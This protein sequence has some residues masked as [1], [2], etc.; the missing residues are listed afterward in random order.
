MISL[1]VCDCRI[2]LRLLWLLLA[3]GP[4]GACSAMVSFLDFGFLLSEEGEKGEEKRA[5]QLMSTITI[6]RSVAAM[7]E[8]KTLDKYQQGATLAQCP[9]ANKHCKYEHQF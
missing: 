5:V 9:A 4:G 6:K 2:G 1:V 8:P 3:A 7:P